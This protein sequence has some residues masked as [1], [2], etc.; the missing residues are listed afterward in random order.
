MKKNQLGRYY[1][2]GKEIFEEIKKKIVE[3][4]NEGC[5]FFEIISRIGVLNYLIIKCVIFSVKDGYFEG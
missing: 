2:N 5:L 1:K 4:Y 3:L